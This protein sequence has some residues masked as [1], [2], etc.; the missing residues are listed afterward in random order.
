M[1]RILLISAIAA[2]TFAPAAY[3]AQTSTSQT[4]TITAQTEQFVILDITPN[5]QNCILD[6]S[7]IG[8][9]VTCGTSTV[10]WQTR[11]NAGATISSTMGPPTAAN[12]SCT[13]QPSTSIPNGYQSG[14]ASVTCTAVHS[15]FITP[16]TYS[17]TLTVNL[18]C[19]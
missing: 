9:T 18:A 17:T 11:C 13:G 1:R 2:L 14:S 7:N 10:S 19:N 16:G 6:A 8:Q 5:T 3:F 15:T 4:L 12:F